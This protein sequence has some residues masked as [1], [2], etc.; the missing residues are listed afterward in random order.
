VVDQGGSFDHA[1]EDTRF[2][3]AVAGFGML[4]RG[5]KNA[6]GASYALID[7]LARSAVGK[8]PG[9]YRAELVTLVDEARALSGEK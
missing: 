3:A 1:S 7:E 2:A 9:G 4:L 6:G 8:D 5:S